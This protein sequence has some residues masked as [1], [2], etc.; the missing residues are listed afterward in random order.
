L[1]KDYQ[2]GRAITC[3]DNLAQAPAR[4]GPWLA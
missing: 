2:L 3:L 4:Q 1:A